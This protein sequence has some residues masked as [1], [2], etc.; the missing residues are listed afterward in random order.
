MRTTTGTGGG[1]K[2]SEDQARDFEAAVEEIKGDSALF[3]KHME[4]DAFSDILVSD[5]PKA[6]AAID[7]KRRQQS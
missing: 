7:K 1:K 6:T 3:L 2:I 5:I 4:A